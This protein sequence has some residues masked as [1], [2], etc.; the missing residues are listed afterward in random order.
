MCKRQQTRPFWCW[1]RDKVLLYCL[2]LA[3]ATKVKIGHTKSASFA[4][5][6]QIVGSGTRFGSR[7]VMLLDNYVHTLS[8][9]L[10]LSLTLLLKLTT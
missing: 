1:E 4:T 10:S 2:V 6:I 8:L 5:K 3:T 9:P 7:L